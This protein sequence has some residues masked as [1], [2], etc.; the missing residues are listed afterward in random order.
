M[1]IR[2]QN[3]LLNSLKSEYSSIV[4]LDI[5]NIIDNTLS[6]F[7]TCRNKRGIIFL[8]KKIS[9]E[10]LP[11]INDDFAHTSLSP[12]G[13]N[14]IIP[15]AIKVVTATREY[16][17]RRMSVQNIIN[18]NTVLRIRPYFTSEALDYIS[19]NIR[20][21][22]SIKVLSSYSVIDNVIDYSNLSFPKTEYN[23]CLN[24]HRNYI[25]FSTTGQSCNQTLF[26]SSKPFSGDILLDLS[27]GVIV[28]YNHVVTF[29]SSKLHSLNC[30]SIEFS[31]TESSTEP[32]VM[33]TDFLETG[34]RTGYIYFKPV[35]IHDIDKPSIVLC[36]NKSVTCE[37]YD[38]DSSTWQSCTGSINCSNSKPLLLRAELSSGDSISDMLLCNR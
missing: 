11:V 21:E 37:Y 3:S 31:F 22:A 19:V 38:I 30:A 10:C 13:P 24:I 34:E 18:P 27:A 28:L 2:N 16:L 20:S 26:C 32:I 5:P 17:A 29:D 23:F 14:Y 36:G 25:D 4:P 15:P 35:N 33:P 8:M 6:D 1:I 12:D 7:Y 9:D